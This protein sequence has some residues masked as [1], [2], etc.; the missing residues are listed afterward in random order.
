MGQK[1]KAI[2]KSKP[3]LEEEKM[4]EKARS[5]DK[6]LADKRGFMKNLRGLFRKRGDF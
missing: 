5:E 3:T 6:K 1:M 4:K 2:S